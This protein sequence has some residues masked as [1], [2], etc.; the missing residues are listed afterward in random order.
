MKRFI[1]RPLT[2]AALLAA[3]AMI[4]AACGDSGTT[5]TTEAPVATEAPTTEAPTTTAPPET[6][7]PTTTEAPFQ[8]PYGG[9]V[10]IADD[11]EPPTLNGFAPGGDNFIVTK[12]AQGYSCGI[13]EIDG[14]TL[15]FI[16]DLLTELPTVGNGGLTVNDDGS[17]TV[18][19]QI[20][21]EA[22]WADGTPISGDDFQFTL[23][24]IMDPDLPIDKTFY[25]DIVSSTPGPKTFEYTLS[26]ATLQHEVRFG[27]ILPKHDLEGKDFIND[28]NDTRWVSCG[29][30]SFDTWQ[31]VNSSS[32]SATTTTGRLTPRRVS[33]F[34][35]STLWCSGSSRRRLP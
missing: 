11:Q 33:S 15:E 30:F 21:D 10:F 1:R 8:K 24:T 6:A 13:Q 9:E 5:T 14:F 16:P 26:G 19:Y 23:D 7:A 17:M 29:P 20:R 28:F 31:K 35:I 3:F 2:W 22:V 12:I 25:E 4:A 27:E 34:R 18:K 32:W